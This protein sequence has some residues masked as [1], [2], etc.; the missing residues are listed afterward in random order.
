[1]SQAIRRKNVKENVLLA[2]LTIEEHKKYKNLK[3]GNVS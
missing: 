2:L 3:L 1:M